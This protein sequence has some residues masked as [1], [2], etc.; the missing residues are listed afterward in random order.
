M[1]VTKYE[2]TSSQAQTFQVEKRILKLLLLLS[3]SS[4]SSSSLT[5]QPSEGYGLLVHEVS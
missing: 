3:S 4:S 5:L 1:T 2:C